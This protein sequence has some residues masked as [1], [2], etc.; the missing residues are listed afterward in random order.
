M[1]PKIEIKGFID[2]SLVDWNGYV[3][4]VI[5]LP[6][7]NFR[8]PF[9]QNSELVLHPEKL[10]T[11]PLSKILD[12]IRD[13]KW[14]LDGVVITGGEPTIHRDL[15]NL[16]SIFKENNLKVKI[17]TNGSNPTMLKT[18]VEEKLIDYVALDVKAPLNPEKYSL[19]T[20]INAEKIIEKIKESI[21]FLIDSKFPHEFRTTIVPTIHTFEDIREIC[22]EIKGCMKYVI[23][24]F[25]P[26]ETIDPKFENLNPPSIEELREFYEI[27]KKIIRNTK[28]RI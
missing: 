2:L 17:D 14:G 24:N 8:C 28:L 16:C 12:Y 5:F 7:C 3:T 20:G 11:I 26:G 22:M 13:Y 4:C 25:R 15:P 19:A 18:L 1:E 9:C 10:K 23:Q 6:K 27:A 21:N